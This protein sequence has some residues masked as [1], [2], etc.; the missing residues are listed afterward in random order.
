[1]IGEWGASTGHCETS[2]RQRY[3]DYFVRAAGKIGAA[4]FLWDNGDDYLDRQ[5]GIW[6]D[7]I[8]I[9][10]LANA[11]KGGPN[12]SLPD[13]TTDGQ[14]TSQN[15]SAFIY[16]KLGEEVTDYELPILF[17]GNTLSSVKLSN[18]TI[19]NSTSDYR[20][21]QSAVTFKSAFLSRFISTSAAPGSKGNFL[22]HFS[23]GAPLRIDIVQWDTPTFNSTSSTA[24]KESG[25]LHIA[26]TYKGLKELATVKMQTINGTYLFDDWTQNLGPLQRARGV[27]EKRPRPQ[28]HLYLLSLT[29]MYTNPIIV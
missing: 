18:G 19:L 29:T 22:L 5:S 27:R 13:G 4:T 10:I 23:A 21:S 17:N 9:Q 14:A 25:D 26:V 28:N 16:H 7:A 8:A 12:N 11:A 6:R 1:M 24:V 3:F 15:S 20:V 2:A